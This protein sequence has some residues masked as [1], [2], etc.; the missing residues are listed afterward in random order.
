[1]HAPSKSRNPDAARLATATDL[2]DGQIL[3]IRVQPSLQKYSASPFGRN[4]FIDS[5]VPLLRGAFRDRHKRGAGCDGREGAIDEQ[6][7][8]G[9]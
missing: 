6:R 3:Q 2:P 1:M 5:S 4:S 8:R 9:R 7:Q